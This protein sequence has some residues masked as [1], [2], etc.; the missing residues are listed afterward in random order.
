MFR[1]SLSLLGLA[2]IAVPASAQQSALWVSD[3][4]TGVVRRVDATGADLIPPAA[5]SADGELAVDAVGSAWALCVPDARLKRLD[6]SGALLLDVATAA[7][8]I[9]LAI[10]AQSRVWVVCAKGERLQR[11]SSAG[12][13]ELDLA[14]PAEPTDLAID[15]AGRVWVSL[16]S[17]RVLRF[18]GDGV[19]LGETRGLRGDLRLAVSHFGFLFA[20]SRNCKRIWRIDLDNGE[21]LAQQRV[22]EKVGDIVAD[23]LGRVWYTL[24]KEHLLVRQD[25][26]GGGNAWV[27]TA[28]APDQ[29]AIDLDGSLWVSSPEAG[30]I[31][32]FDERGVLLG[33]VASGDFGLGGDRAGAHLHGVLRPFEDLDQDGFANRSEWIGESRIDD[34]N[35]VPARIQ[36]TVLAPGVH[37]LALEAVPF[38]RLGYAAFLTFSA[39]PG[40]LLSLLG[41]HDERLVST[42]LGDPLFLATALQPG[43]IDAPIGALDS[44]GRATVRVVLP[45]D[46]VPPFPVDFAF[47]AVGDSYAPNFIRAISK[48]VRLLS[49]NE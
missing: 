39:Q 35:S 29:L 13:L 8:P 10:D 15:E 41:N 16:R 47:L 38:P 40:S 48:P 33:N 37:E 25:A 24:P 9:A 31:Q 36:H 30:L 43:L 2:A 18:D 5:V 7:E 49:P 3:Q 20:A 1:R 17:K 19:L 45:P 11:F 21:V 32:R 12:A 46:L 27:L 28:S 26:N 42:D 14:L 44:R 4:S 22:R 6:P 34:A 23:R